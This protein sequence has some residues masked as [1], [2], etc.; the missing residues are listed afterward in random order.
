MML[1]TGSY[2][3]IATAGKSLTTQIHGCH[4]L[5]GRVNTMDKRKLGDGNS[6]G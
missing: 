6:S 1:Y 4:G 2:P 3:S 5:V